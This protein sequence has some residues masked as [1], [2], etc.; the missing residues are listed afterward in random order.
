[1]KQIPLLL[2]NEKREKNDFCALEENSKR[3]K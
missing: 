3:S 2:K 1:M